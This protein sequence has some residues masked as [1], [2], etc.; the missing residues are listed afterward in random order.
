MGVVLKARDT[1]LDRD[2]ALKFLTELGPAESAEAKR[3]RAEARSL[4]ALS[5]PNIVTIYDV[6][7]QDGSPFLVLE[8]V[9]GTDLSRAAVARP[10]AEGVSAD[11]CA[12]G[13]RRSAAP[14][15]GTSCIAISNQERPAG[16]DRA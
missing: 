7:E 3:L 6:S 12:R 10:C 13:P 14:T 5:H 9:Q 11:R 1:R 8:W 4:A 16:D 2:V 15:R